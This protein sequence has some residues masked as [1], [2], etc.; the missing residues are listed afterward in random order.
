MAWAQPQSLSLKSP[1]GE[2]E[3]R[4]FIATA[5]EDYSLPRAAYQ[6]DF[7]GKPLMDT[8]FFGIETDGQPMLG[9]NVTIAAISTKSVDETYTVPAGKAKVVRNR[10]NQAIVQYA[11]SSTLGRKLTVEA[12]VYDDGVAFRYYIPWAL[13]LLDLRMTDEATQ[14]RFAQDADSYP[15][16]VD[17]FKTNYEDQYHKMTLSGIH[18][19]SL[20][21][22]PFLVEQP[23][24]G[25]VAITEAQID[26]YAG[27]YLQHEEGRAM[28]STLSKRYAEPELA[29][30]GTVPR[31]CPWRVLLIAD[32]PGKLIESNIVQSLNPPSAIADTSWIKPGKAAWNWWSG[33]PVNTATVDRYIDFAAESKLEYMLID[34]GWSQSGE[35]RLPPDLTKTIPALDLPELLL[36]A[37]SKNVGVWLWADWQSVQHQ[38]DQAFPLFEKWG[39]AGVKMDLMNRDDQTMIN[40]YRTVAKKAAEHHLMIDFHG[41]FKPDGIERTYPNVL[42]REAVMGEKYSKWGARVTPDHDVM[43]AYTRLLAGPIDYTP[44]GFNNVARAA[45]V[46]REN[47][48]M[49]MGTRA[50]QLALYVVFE[51]PLTMVS[52]DPEAYQGQK[53]FDFIKAVPASW[54]ETK[55]V[56][57][58]MGEFITVARKRGDEWYLGSITNWT[59]R[60]VEMPLEFLG[61]GDYI[62]EVY[63]DAADADLNPKHTSIEQKRVN[64]SMKL[65]LNL[66]SGGGAAVRFRPAS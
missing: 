54:D 51:S 66:A 3:L 4:L 15:L 10:Y 25:W 40:F 49:V 57:G 37:K 1:N 30:H 31:D 9:E 8:S 14:F 18:P 53:D 19:D 5:A 12:R 32:N 11:Q 62:A 55:F 16:L 33:A 36:R 17:N 7:R 48:P 39:I 44:G 34:Q 38:M 27:M 46:P 6:V 21:A 60:E 20:I 59:S 58:R 45:F 47:K 50:H 2:I 43:L 26:D 63:A 65:K 64:A 61:K 13:P 35:D 28:I 56:N 24:V 29:V 23:G 42:T 52:D 41:A 22:L